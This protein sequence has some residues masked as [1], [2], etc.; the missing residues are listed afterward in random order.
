MPLK[1]QVKSATIATTVGQGAT[2]FPWLLH[3]TFDPYLI[4]RVLSKVAS[5]TIFWVFGMIRPGIEPWSTRPLANTLLI[6]NMIL[7]VTWNPI[8]VWKQKNYYQIEI[9]ACK[10]M[11]FSIRWK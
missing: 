9:I 10:Y 7:L 4:V 11:F 1:Q 3:L 2:P 6:N 5:S 8:T